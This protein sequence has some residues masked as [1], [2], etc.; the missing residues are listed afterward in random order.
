MFLINAGNI[1]KT[2]SVRVWCYLRLRRKGLFYG[3]RLI[4]LWMK[5]SVLVSRRSVYIPGQL[6]S[7]Q[8]SMLVVPLLEKVP[9]S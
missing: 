3:C 6:S 5:K 7:P 9:N 4:P 2:G 8:N 1:I